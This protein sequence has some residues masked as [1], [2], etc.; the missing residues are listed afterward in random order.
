MLI[1]KYSYRLGLLIGDLILLSF[2]PT[3]GFATYKIALKFSDFA[4]RH[5]ISK[6]GSDYISENLFQCLQYLD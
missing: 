2:L 6:Y 3:S 5:S 4:N 1:E